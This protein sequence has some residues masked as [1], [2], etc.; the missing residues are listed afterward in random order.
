M[1]VISFKLP[2]Q[3]ECRKM[4]DALTQE[5]IGITYRIS[6]SNPFTFLLGINE[7]AVYNFKQR[8][9]QID[10]DIDP[11]SFMEVFGTLLQRN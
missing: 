1:I 9:P 3:A 11:R 10:Y 4:I 8:F 7:V 5:Q 2:D 6:G